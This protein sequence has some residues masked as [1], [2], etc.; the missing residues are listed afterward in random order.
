MAFSYFSP[1]KRI[2]FVSA[3]LFCFSCRQNTPDICRVV[4]R[5]SGTSADS[6]ILRRISLNNGSGLILDAGLLRFSRDSLVFEL[7]LSA[8]SLYEFSLKFSSNRIYCIPDAREINILMNKK[9]GKSEISGSPASSSVTR[10]NEEQD[11]LIRSL[12]TLQKRNTAVSK[13]EQKQSD[14]IQKLKR[15]IYRKLQDRYVHFADTVSSSAAFI[16][17]YDHI[18]FGSDSKRMK[19]VVEN[20][21][22]RFH[23][24]TAISR[25][26]KEVLNL[27][28][29]Q[30]MELQV[31]D[32]FPALNLPDMDGRLFS[33]KEASGKYIYIDFWSSWCQSC[34]LYDKVRLE[35]SKEKNLQNLV[36]IHVALD[37]HLKTCKEII[38]RNKMPGIQLIDKDIWQGQ[39]ANKLAIDSIPFN[40]LIGPDQHILAK[41]IPA[42]SVLVIIR[43]HIR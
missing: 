26:Y 20:A 36:L 6:L 41:A 25:L 18:D 23:G 34:M 22:K 15:E 29:I 13:P 21:M 9:T 19:S 43:N 16:E 5:M 8:D 32:I 2:L 30:D 31:G 28:H 3:I 40:F 4:V 42:D 37:N 33:T 24:S 11:S 14:S 39:T 7:P 38:E 10:F 17:N 35:I 12:Q 27:I 1:M